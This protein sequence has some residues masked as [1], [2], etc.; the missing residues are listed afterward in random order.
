MSIEMETPETLIEK[1]DAA[2]NYIGQARLAS[3][4]GD[5][6]KLLEVLDKAG[7]LL[8]ASMEILQE[9]SSDDPR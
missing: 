7:E 4:V 3:A 5:Q 1:I 9:A 2:W 6:V 8:G